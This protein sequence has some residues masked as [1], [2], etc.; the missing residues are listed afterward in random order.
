MILGSSA[1]NPGTNDEVIEFSAGCTIEGNGAGCKVTEPFVTSNVKSELIESE[2]GE[3]GSLLM[4]FK[5]E[6]G[7]KLVTL[8]FEGLGC[9][10]K[11]IV[12]SGEVA[13]EVFADPNNKELGE[14]VTFPLEN[15]QAGSW[16]INFPA[17]PIKKTWLIKSGAGSEVTLK[18]LEAFTEPATLTGTALVSLA[19]EQGEV[20]ET[21]WGFNAGGFPVW[22]VEGVKL[23]GA[24]A[25]TVK[26]KTATILR[27][28]KLEVECT[29][30]TMG[31]QEIKSP[32]RF[33]VKN[34]KF[35]KCTV[36][37]PVETPGV[38]KCIVVGGNIEMRQPADLRWEEKE[39]EGA[40]LAFT[41]H[42]EFEIKAEAPLACAVT[43][44]YRVGAV[45]LAELKNAANEE[46]NK[47]I[48]FKCMPSITKF[49]FGEQPNRFGGTPPALEIEKV[50]VFEQG[51]LW[52][53]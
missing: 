22:Y 26:A 40:L 20:E 50:G 42:A 47:K 24:E 28:G 10:V 14:R 45:L 41:P 33:E 39:G 15:R 44:S 13:G 17:T 21:F 30:A 34:V 19:N 32:A 6:K 18:E 38:E 7:V 49:W 37:K 23:V 35:E 25:L 12:V 43:G 5:P 52:G 51:E 29:T 3:K 9:T 4:E 11:E 46:K 1:G 48:T 2:K 31:T 16:L 53:I 8:H 36:L 27:N